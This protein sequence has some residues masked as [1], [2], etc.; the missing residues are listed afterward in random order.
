MHRF[1]NLQLELFKKG[2]FKKFIDLFYIYIYKNYSTDT[3]QQ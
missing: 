3:K 1:F 2:T